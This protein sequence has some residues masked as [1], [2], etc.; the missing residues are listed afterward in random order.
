MATV[1]P[2][3]NSHPSYSA[4]QITNA[5]SDDYRCYPDALS[6]RDIGLYQV[7]PFSMP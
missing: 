1:A 2:P 4:T 6:G 3:T 7:S 5:V